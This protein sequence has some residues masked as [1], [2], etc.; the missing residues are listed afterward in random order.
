M[1]LLLVILVLPLAGC[2]P[3]RASLSYGGSSVIYDGEK[4]I[5]GI[6]G[7]EISR[8]ISGYSK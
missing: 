8:G 7:D 1:K 6:D 2:V 4:V 3:Y 5:V